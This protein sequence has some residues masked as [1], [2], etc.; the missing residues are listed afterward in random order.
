MS[1]YSSKGQWF[2]IASAIIITMI[3]ALHN[4]NVKKTQSKTFSFDIEKTILEKTEFLTSKILTEKF[5]NDRKLLIK[6]MISVFD[7]SNSLAKP[8]GMEAELFCICEYNNTTSN[9]LVGSFFNSIVNYSISSQ[10]SISDNISK[11]E[12]KDHA[13]SIG[14]NVTIKLDLGKGNICAYHYYRTNFCACII[15]I[16]DEKNRFVGKTLNLNWC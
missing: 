16:S 15:F 9:I 2:L 8:K 5:E 6:N 7:V 14:N 10:S 13:I 1:M 11:L 3:A 4:I 12:F